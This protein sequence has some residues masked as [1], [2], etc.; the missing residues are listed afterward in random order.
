MRLDYVTHPRKVISLPPVG[1]SLGKVNLKATKKAMKVSQRDKEFTERLL[2][3]P[4]S[5]A[6]EKSVI[7][8]PQALQNIIQEFQKL[9]KKS[10]RQIYAEYGTEVK[11]NSFKEITFYLVLGHRGKALPILVDTGATY[12]LISE[13]FANILSIRK[14]E[15]ANHIRIQ[16]VSGDDIN[17]VKRY[18][19]ELKLDEYLY[20]NMSF[21]ILPD[22]A[23][24]II[25][26]I[27]NIIT[28][29]SRLRYETVVMSVKVGPIRA[30]LQLYPKTDLETHFE[31]LEEDLLGIDTDTDTD[32]EESSDNESLGLFYA[33]QYEE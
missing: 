24:P 14:K 2:A 32:S 15:L 18:S 17:I 12:S 8:L 16:P 33:P 7:T 31:E 28:L 3:A 5:L 19:L 27:Y 6:L 30:K 13:E 23:V 10:K 4:K 29:N 1:D 25:L 9:K 21:A 20:V 11:R 26:G 22:C